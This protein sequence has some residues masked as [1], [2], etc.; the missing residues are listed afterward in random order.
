MARWYSF[1]VARLAAHANRDERLNVGLVVF[2]E[3]RL[4]VRPAKNLEKVRAISAAL[5]SG[6]VRASIERLVELDQML[7]SSESL[8]E[9]RSRLEALSS[10][11]PL[12]FSVL[13]QFEAHSADAYERAIGQILSR[14]V[15][16]EAAPI[17]KPVRRSRLLSSIKTALKAERVMARKGEDL[18]AHRVVAG[19]PLA[20]GLSVDL[21]LKNGAMHAI[22]TVDAQSEEISVRKLVSDIAV[23]ALVLERARMTFGE[24]ETTGRL[25]YNATAYNESIAKPSLLAAEHQGAMLVN[26]ASHDDR[27]R[28]ISD[29]ARLAIPLEKKDGLAMLNASTQARFDIN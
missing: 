7:Q 10:I 9:P 17:R 29:I 27:L 16:P 3:G 8:I 22:E 12:E 23:S 20:E 15:E 1:A 18:S 25:V 6:V 28:L 5:D 14:L 19:W 13:G 24:G 21:L 26:W 11:S 4:D 2:D